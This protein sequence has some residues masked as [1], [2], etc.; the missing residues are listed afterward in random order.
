MTYPL[1]DL[2]KIARKNIL[3]LSPYRCARDVSHTIYLIS[4][5]SSVITRHVVCDLTLT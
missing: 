2:Q 4:L 3:E 1:F 5:M